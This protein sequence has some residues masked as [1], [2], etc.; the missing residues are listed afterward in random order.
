MLGLGRITYLGRREGRGLGIGDW[1]GL[2]WVG[3]VRLSVPD[4]E[5]W[6]HHGLDGDGDGDG[7]DDDDIVDDR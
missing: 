2:G 6:I 5:I 1:V 4:L 7:D 3:L